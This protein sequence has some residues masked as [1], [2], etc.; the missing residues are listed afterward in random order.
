MQEQ[1]EETLKALQ[2]LHA[3]ELAALRSKCDSLLEAMNAHL[4]HARGELE[5]AMAQVA[6]LQGEMEAMQASDTI[7]QPSGIDLTPVWHRSD[8]LLA[9]I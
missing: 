5:K 9:S 4:E 3:Q 8:T 7:S 1:H 2:Q 6:A